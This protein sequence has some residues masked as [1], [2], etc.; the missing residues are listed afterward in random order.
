MM[1]DDRRAGASDE[2]RAA[3]S[4]AARRRRAAL[5]PTVAR[6][7]EAVETGDLLAIACGEQR[8]EA[9]ARAASGLT[10]ALVLWYPPSDALP[11]EGAPAS[12][13]VA[14]QRCAALAALAG[15][16]GRRVLLVTDAAAASQRIAGPG[17]VSPGLALE[18]GQ[19]IDAEDFAASLEAIG[20]FQD[21]RVDEAGEFAVRGAVVDIFPADAEE[22]VRIRLDEGRVEGIEPYDPATQLGRGGAL[23]RLAIVPSAEPEGQAATL[24]DYL[25]EA[26]VALDPETEERRRTYLDLARESGGRGAALLAEPEWEAALAGRD[27]LLL[28]EGGEQAGRR[29][30][31]ARR[32][33]WALAAAISEARERG[34]R[35]LFTGS[36]RD[37]RFLGR[38]I[39]Q[40]LGEAP[41]PIETWREV[42]GAAAGTLLAAAVELDAGW[43]EPGLMVVTAADMLGSRTHADAPGTPDP[44]MLEAAEFHAGDAVIHE[45]HGLAV[46]RGLECVGSGEEEGDAFRLEH[47]GGG[48]R[49]V[50]V[51]EGRKLWRYGA[52]ADAVTLDRLDGSSWEKRRGEIAGTLAETARQL[53]E[54]ARVREARSAPVLEPPAADYERFVTGFPYSETPDQIRAVEAVRADLASGKPM[55]RLVVGDVGYG[56]TEVALRAAALAVLAGKQVAVVAPTTVLVRQHVETFRR[57]FRRLGVE[58]AGLSRLTPSREARAVKSGIA[59]GSVR[60]VV[61]TKMLAGKTVAFHDLGLVAIDEE[62]R[63]GA[64]DKARLRS[65]GE[66]AH[67]LTLTATPIPRTLQTALVGLQDLSVIATPPARRQP[68]RTQ[69][70]PFAPEL[71]R[72]ALL[73]ERRRGGQSFLVVPRI[74]DMA[75]MAEQLARL[76]P[77]LAVRSVHGRMPAAEADE[78]MVRFASGDGDLL[79]ATNIIESGLDI[80]RANT[81]LAWRADRFGLAQLH[82]LRGRVGRGR[83]RGHML[84]LTEE[85]AEIAPAT[86]KRLRTM[87]ALDRLGAG[88]AV[89]AR[90]LDLRGAGELLGEEQAGHMKLIGV[91][92]YQHLLG[93]AIRAARGETV[94]DWLPELRLGVPGRIPAEW[95]PEEDVRA[96]LYVRVARVASAAQEE[97]LAEELEDRF[98]ALP[99]ETERLMALASIRR[100]AREARVAR[101][102]AGPAAIALTPRPDFFANADDLE[103]KGERLLLRQ[104]SEPDERRLALVRSLLE[105]LAPEA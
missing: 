46:L 14:G 29:F 58:V 8:G 81:M 73:R 82:Q 75:G 57:R 69:V 60:I 7:C 54:L 42:R 86:L 85:G 59:D 71:I 17:A 9:I 32:P 61:G 28:S 94:D 16:E 21:E 65:L 93:Q 55:D 36:R 44:L 33:E 66:G 41:R 25:P 83:A 103:R 63:F 20:Y 2:G 47:G 4:G 96:N 84:L 102:D 91:G 19:A 3:A 45:D 6:L 76:V 23:D 31:E 87:E 74:E 99:E 38:R 95:V 92:L 67:V 98:G 40:A 53:V 50:P 80:P 43:V 48:Q 64:A 77:Q 10:D 101:V 104:P 18:A 27:R 11:G 62:Q 72:A 70:A 52:E 1:L 56:K 5:G 15:R 90:D 26:R 35:I 78:E 51:E 89:S 34:D 97:A 68:T 24:F 30:V 88:F 105:R 37:L 49:L 13:A 79:L 22:P 100:L 12:P 39:E